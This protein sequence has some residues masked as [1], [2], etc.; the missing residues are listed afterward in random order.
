MHQNSFPENLIKGRIAETIFELMFREATDFDIYPLGYEHTTPILRQYRDHQDQPQPHKE[1]LAR[2]LD[3][4]DNAPD[5]LL[6]K[7]DKSA[8]YLVEVKY[9]N[10]ELNTESNL[11]IA[12]EINDKWKPSH[13]FLA[14]PEAFYYDSCQTI[15]NNQG[16]I[17]RL[18]ESIIPEEKQTYYHQLLMRFEK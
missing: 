10:E 16:Q 17:T 9:R 13:L 3:N 6:T 1:V 14:T 18:K 5:F 15:I 11:T 12:K 4:F 2:V 7:S 8:I